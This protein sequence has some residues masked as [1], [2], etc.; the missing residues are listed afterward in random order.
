[1]LWRR[2]L[3]FDIVVCFRNLQTAEL[4]NAGIIEHTFG[5]LQAKTDVLRQSLK[6][7]TCSGSKYEAAKLRAAIVSWICQASSDDIRYAL[8]SWLRAARWMVGSQA[9]CQSG[10]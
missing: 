10:T 9:D 7:G 3:A 2:L 4:L 1:M 8:S 6:H 5:D